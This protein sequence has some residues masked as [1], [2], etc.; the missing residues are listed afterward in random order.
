MLR[1]R[2]LR[3]DEIEVRVAQCSPK[4]CSLLL[5]K[6]ARTDA[7][8]LDETVG[9]ENWACKFYSIDGVLF[10]SIGIRIARDDGTYEWVWK[11]DCGTAGNIEKE[12]STASDCFKRAG[13]KWSIGRELYSAPFCWV[14][15]QNCNIKQGNNGKYQC[16][17]RFSC[18]KIKIEDGVI[19]GLAIRNDTINRRVLV[20]TKH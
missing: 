19:T 20:W 17:D 2:D 4:G 3:A 9:P 8:I 11:D 12:K 1:F 14:N 6:T 15:S 10:C 5:Y 18:E 7:N 16:Y 13:F